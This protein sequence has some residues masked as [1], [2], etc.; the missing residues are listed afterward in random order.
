MSCDTQDLPWPPMSCDTQ[1]LPWPPMSCDTQDLPWPPMSCD[2][3]SRVCNSS[4]KL[5]YWQTSYFWRVINHVSIHF[6]LIQNC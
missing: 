4:E 2:T 3:A 1:D 6:F 5:F